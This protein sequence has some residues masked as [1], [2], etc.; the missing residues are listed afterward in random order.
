MTFRQRSHCGIAFGGLSNVDF[1]VHTD[2]PKTFTPS[3][4][5]ITHP[6]SFKGLSTPRTNA[7][8]VSSTF[9]DNPLDNG[10]PPGPSN[11]AAAGCSWG[12][13]ESSNRIEEL[14]ETHS[15]KNDGLPP[16]VI[17]KDNTLS[18]AMGGLW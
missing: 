18:G 2:N 6:R 8:I 3:P 12:G 9:F 11:V 4:V 10:V 15:L 1:Y 16:E 17:S 5:W 7:E 13:S 14:E